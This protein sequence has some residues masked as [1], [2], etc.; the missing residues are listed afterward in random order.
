M[1][2]LL[3][4]CVFILLIFSGFAQVK[5]QNLHVSANGRYLQWNIETPFFIN[6]CTAWTLTYAYSDEEIIEYLDNRVVSKFN[7]IQMSAVFAELVKTIADS[8]FLNRDLLQPV[9]KF[10][11]RVD[12]V[13]KHATD[14]GLVVMINP[15]WKNSLND[16]IHENG[17]EKCRKYGQWFANR[18]KDNSRVIYFIGGNQ[19]PG[20]VRDEM[21]EMAKGIQDVYA[22]KAILAYHSQADQSGREAFPDAEWMTLNWTY[23]YSPDY[24]KRFPYSEN[25]DNWKTFPNIPIYFGQGYYDFGVAKTYSENGVAERWGD[26][27]AIRRQAWWNF[28]SGGMGNAWGAEG[29][30]NKNA[31]DENWKLCTEYGS[32]K[33]M[34][35]MQ[36]LIA[37]IKW[38]KLQ[39]D[40]D[41]QLLVDGNNTFM[42]D[43]YAVCS[44]ADNGS[45]AVIY[46]PAQ[47]SLELNLPDFG[48]HC[49]LRWFDPTN[50]KYITIDMRFPKKKKKSVIL[51]PPALNHSGG[52]DWVLVIVGSRLK[53]PK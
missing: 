32:S 8:A 21:T 46:S 39:P 3:I 34:G 13:V 42:T 22:G 50:G 40:I 35:I 6:A 29:I 16:L 47:Q 49:R 7:T 48:Q 19:S 52:K 43:N 9:P 37:K 27:L 4:P 31:E 44:I 5:P 12:W 20:P 18:F 2:K 41:H 15:I 17:P 24:L 11:D 26:R 51:T 1:K 30:W 10:W 38:S 36:E 33:D 53:P 14:R 45:L 23:A 25:Y 28:L